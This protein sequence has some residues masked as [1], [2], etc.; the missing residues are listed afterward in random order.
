MEVVEHEQERSARCEAGERVVDG[1]EE[2]M[3]C[4]GVIAV[5]RLQ[6][7]GRV[8][9]GSASVNG[10]NGASGS[11]E[12]RPSSTVAPACEDGRRE[13]ASEARLADPGL[14]GD[15]HDAAVAMHLHATP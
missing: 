2:A 5:A 3:A 14:A 15:E 9:L 1:V 10:S 8:R 11:S 6:E 4:A 13:L 7:L 12:Q